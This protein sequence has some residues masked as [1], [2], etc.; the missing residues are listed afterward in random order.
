M[1]SSGV[2]IKIIRGN[3]A[4]DLR[5][6]GDKGIVTESRSLSSSPGTMPAMV[7]L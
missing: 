3:A 6:N 5:P 7:T 4:E 2:F 1:F